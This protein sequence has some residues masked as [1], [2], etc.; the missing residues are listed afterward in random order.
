M[1]DKGYGVED[2]IGLITVAVIVIALGFMLFEMAGGSKDSAPRTS[3]HCEVEE[4]YMGNQVVTCEQ[5]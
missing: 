3:T 2:V 4:G 1:K 5:D